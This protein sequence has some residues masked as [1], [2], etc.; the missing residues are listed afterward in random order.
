VT[1]IPQKK[2]KPKAPEAFREKPKV[3]EGF[4]ENPKV[5]EGFQELFSD[6]LIWL[7]ICVPGSFRNF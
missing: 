6:P 1:A 4:R 5:P 7:V 3:P 2:T